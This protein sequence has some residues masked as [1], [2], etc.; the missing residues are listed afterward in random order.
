MFL[1]DW[2]QAHLSSNSIRVV[3]KS[4]HNLI[5]SCQMVFTCR[6]MQPN[7][8]YVEHLL[9]FIVHCGLSVFSIG[10]SCKD[11]V[12]IILSLPARKSSI[13]YVLCEKPDDSP[14]AAGLY[15][16]TGGHCDWDQMVIY[17]LRW[18]LVWFLKLKYKEYVWVYMRVYN[19]ISSI[20]LPP[21]IILQ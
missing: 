15:S 10:I 8:P 17:K 6:I 2:P 20:Y 18:A 16:G 11:R 3:G 4:I 9:E 12:H 14:S 7:Y 13:F 5:S 21:G 19:N 1:W